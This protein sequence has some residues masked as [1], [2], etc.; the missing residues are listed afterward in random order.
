MDHIFVRD[1]RLQTLIGFH[2]RERL[3]PQT[4]RIDLEIGIANTAVFSSDKVADCIDYD[5][6]TTRIREVSSVHVNLVETLAERVA[7]LL[8]D[9][10]GAAWVKVSIA[11][12][13]IL[14]DVGL[15]GVTVERRRS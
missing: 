9:E 7:R 8:L 10:F 4:I 12:L 15:V 13:G 6:V 14:K 11:K 2:R 1:L 3:V 5:K